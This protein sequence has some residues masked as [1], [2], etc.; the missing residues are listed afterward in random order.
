M[1]TLGPKHKLVI[2]GAGGWLGTELLELLLSQHGS[3]CLKESVVC[4][5]TRKRQIV[6]SDGTSLEILPFFESLEIKDVSGFVHLAFLTRDK[7]AQYG[8]EKYTFT[9]L[10]ITSRAIELIETLNPQW[11]ATVSS[12]AV[13]SSPGG[14]LENN[15]QSNPYGFTKRVEETMLSD[16]ANRI[17][18]HLSIG[19]L[20]GAMGK[21]MPVNQAYAVSDFIIQATNSNEIKIKSG[22]KVWRRYCDA[23]VFMDVLTSSAE[24]LELTRFDSGGSL[25][26][27]GNLAELISDLSNVNITIS[28]APSVGDDD[29]Y[30]PDNQYFDE[31]AQ[32]SHISQNHISDLLSSTFKSHLQQLTV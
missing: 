25:I 6:L 21:F 24:K 19:R 14:P 32:L 3:E 20:W 30:Y 17:G 7:V 9:N 2:T 4:M 27:I 11:I 1:I 15:L 23:S 28:R 8:T 5:G 26:E 29:N 18:A 22:N 13:L 10:S 12:G 31:L 16:T